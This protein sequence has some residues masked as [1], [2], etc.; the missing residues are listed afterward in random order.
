VLVQFV[1]DTNGRV[2]LQS[3]EILRATHEMFAESVRRWL[4]GTRY[5][6]AE[7]RGQH[8]RQLVQQQIGFTLR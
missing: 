2:E 4:N 1:V 8:V 7:I 6:P 3:L 5:S